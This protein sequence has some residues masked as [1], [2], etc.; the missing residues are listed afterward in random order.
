MKHLTIT[1]SLTLLT[2]FVSA[3]ELI[4][5]CTFQIKIPGQSR[6]ASTVYNIIKTEDKLI[7]KGL[8]TINGNKVELQD[9]VAQYFEYEVRENVSRNDK[10]L[11]LAEKLI[12]GTQE[13]LDNPELGSAFSV[14]LDL[15]KI[16]KAKVF[17][18]GKF[19]HMGGI[20]I[21][22]AQ[23]AEEKVLGSFVTGFL[24]FACE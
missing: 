16:R 17:Q 10:D 2:S 21:I 18:V 1:L 23:D 19:T 3:S 8:Q 6:I 13:F 20:A 12:T 7:A 5:S 24:P 22:E 11:N 4:K 15:K 9:E 14:N